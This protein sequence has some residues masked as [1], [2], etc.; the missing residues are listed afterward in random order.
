MKILSA[1]LEL[2]QATDWSIDTHGKVHAHVF[3]IS[4]QI[5]VKF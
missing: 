1:V 5:P 3:A 4:L 2:L